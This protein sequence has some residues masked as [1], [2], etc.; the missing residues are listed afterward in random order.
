[1]DHGSYFVLGFIQSIFNDNNTIM[2]SYR[3]DAETPHSPLKN[4]LTRTILTISKRLLK[5]H[6]YLSAR[7]VDLIIAEWRETD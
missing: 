6:G 2:T 3:V 5:S 1:M 7:T 4:I